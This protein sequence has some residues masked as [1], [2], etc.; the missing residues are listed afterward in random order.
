MEQKFH[1][2]FYTGNTEA[3][4][5]DLTSVRQGT[6]KSI[7]DYFKRFKEIKSQCFNLSISDK[8]N[9]EGFEYYSIN[10]LQ[11]RA[12]NQEYK[13]R[14]DKE[15][16]THRSNTHVDCTSNNSDDGN[17]EVYVAELVWPSEGKIFFVIA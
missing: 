13:F 11:L 8:E 10:Q 17:K 7:S 15:S 16:E 12:L 4:L 2:H 5:I 1:D 3:K 9:L 14:K 6:N